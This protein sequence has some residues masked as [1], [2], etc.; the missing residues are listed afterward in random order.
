MEDA[1]TAGYWTARETVE[2]LERLELGDLL[3][4][5]VQARI[6]L[7]IVPDLAAVWDEIVESTLAFS[8]IRLRNL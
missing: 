1:E 5:H 7:R 2:P 3:V 6:E 8:G 4:R